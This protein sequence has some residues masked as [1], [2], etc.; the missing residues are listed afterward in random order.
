MPGA[1]PSLKTICMGLPSCH[2]AGLH[3]A[4]EVTCWSRH[5]SRRYRDAALAA[6][7][8]QSHLPQGCCLQPHLPQRTAMFAVPMGCLSALH[9]MSWHLS[10]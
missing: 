9:C 2:T 6:V 5:E 8:R 10:M 7:S 1:Q 4:T 3:T